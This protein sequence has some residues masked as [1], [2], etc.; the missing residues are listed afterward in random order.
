MA[1]LRVTP[2]RGRTGG[3]VFTGPVTYVMTQGKIETGEWSEQG[4]GDYSGGVRYTSSFELQAKPD[5]QVLLDLG[6]VRGTA[7]V[8]VNGKL[9]AVRVWSPYRFDISANLQAGQNNVEILIF[10]TLAPYLNAVSPT[11]YIH[12][13]QTVS[14][15]IDLRFN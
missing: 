13:G 14:G 12:P 9:V 1:V 4:L 8:R 10:N 2:E 3:G 7:E 6:R 11:H 15:L 5:K